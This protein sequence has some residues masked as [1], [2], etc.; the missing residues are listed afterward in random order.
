MQI[1][2]VGLGRMGFH[3]ASRLLEKGLSVVAYDKIRSKVKEISKKGALGADSLGDLHH[4]LTAKNKAIWIMLPAGDAVHKTIHELANL[5]S[6]GDTVVD[7]GNSFYKDSIRHSQILKAKG[8]QFLD[9]GVSGGVW[10]RDL[11][12][13]LMV[14]GE[15]KA[16]KTLKPVFQ[17]LTSPNE[18]LYCGPAGAGHFVKM[19]HNGIEYGIMQSYAE[20]FGILNRSSYKLDLGNIGHLWNRG[21][22]IRSWLL[23]LL[24]QSLRKDP[25]LSKVTGRI[26]DT[27]EGRWTVQQAVESG[28]STPVLALSLFQRFRSRD[29]D[30]FSDKIV[31]AL[32]REFGGHPVSI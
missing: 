21:S 24:A 6:K 31:S 9:A 15:L 25:K 2:L 5:L 26:E 13:C 4:K 18:Y 29:K 7:G 11:G 8:I 12:Y 1:G 10:G 32:R 19:V 23:E 20:G 22:V 27:G 17:A 14:G 30:V 3:M 28:I 16:F